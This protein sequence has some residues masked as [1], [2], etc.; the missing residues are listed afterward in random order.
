M[1]VAHVRENLNE[2]LMS[3]G[4]IV[5]MQ[6][7]KFNSMR[8]QVDH[9]V[10][11][12]KANNRT[13]DLAASQSS[14][15]IAIR[16]TNQLKN[17]IRENISTSL[18]TE[19]NLKQIRE[20]LLKCNLFSFNQILGNQNKMQGTLGELCIYFQLQNEL[21]AQDKG[22]NVFVI[23]FDHVSLE[24]NNISHFQSAQ[25]SQYPDFLVLDVE[26]ESLRLTLVEVK[27]EKNVHTHRSTMISFYL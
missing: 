15:V 10:F 24:L 18:G 5:C 21:N 14:F 9:V 11:E 13:S 1:H 22:F 8:N 16:N 6:L 3:Q 20:T 17:R 12:M 19:N 4:Q 7:A 2:E 27:L 23:P 25:W 26:R